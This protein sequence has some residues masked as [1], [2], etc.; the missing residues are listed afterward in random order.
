MT[1]TLTVDSGRWSAHQQGVLTSITP[2]LT[3]GSVVPVIKGNGYGVGRDV[4]AAQ[5]NS[6]GVEVIA[7]G[8]VFE[9]AAALAGF[10][11]SVVV[12][13][14]FD[15][16][17]ASASAAWTALLDASADRVIVT[18]ADPA[19]ATALAERPGHQRVLLEG[20]T[21]MRRFG[22]TRERIL[23][24]LAAVGDRLAIAGLSLHLPL[25][26]PEPGR[27]DPS[28]GSLGN[29]LVEP[30][31]T[32]SGRVREVANWQR[33][34][35][36]VCEQHAVDV[37]VSHLDERELSDLRAAMPDLPVHLRLGTRLWLGDRE[38][39][40]A[41]GIVLE[42][43]QVR[44]GDRVGYR[45]RRA[46]DGLLLVVGGGT[47]HGVGLDAPSAATSARQRAVSVG[48]GVL[49]AA[50]RTLSP[51]RWGEVRL[52]FAEPPHMQVSMLWL[53][54]KDFRGIAPVVGDAVACEVRFTTIYPDVVALTP[55]T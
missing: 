30:V 50:G 10:A 28:P 36:T 25:S 32:G 11:G 45:Q 8:T 33:W 26:Q 23:E 41:N 21:S 44:G 20:V 47:A 15:P 18:V 34:W 16:R 42:V 2:L 24:T 9:A 5:A 38:A 12:L 22:M 35:L 54:R 48:T 1:F 17:D 51:F 52:W 39:L 7:V 53:P 13:T 29:P 14:P 37:W 4:L 6:L 27:P 3:G 55:T 49:D 19:A 43:H 46:K 40:R 31:T